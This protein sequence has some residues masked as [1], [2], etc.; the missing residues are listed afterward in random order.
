MWRGNDVLLVQRG[1]SLGYGFWSLPGGKIEPDETAR[2]AAVR[3]LQEE[4]G[5]SADLQF[6]AGDFDLDGGGLHYVISCFTGAYIS[7]D[8]RAMTDAKAVAWVQWQDIGTYKLAPGTA[9]AIL[10]A[11]K[12][13]SV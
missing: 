13:T 1:K 6:H 10:R 12:L 7:G 2:E 11:R 4:T 9:D 8:A 5:I 3:E